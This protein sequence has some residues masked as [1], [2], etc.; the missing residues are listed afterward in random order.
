MP[1]AQKSD[2][3]GWYRVHAIDGSGLDYSTTVYDPERHV[4][5]V[6]DASDAFG[7]PNPPSAAAPVEKPG[8]ASPARRSAA[9]PKTANKTSVNKPEEATA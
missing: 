6:D 7:N 1:D 8:S 4:L 5:V 3:H 2:L 9:R